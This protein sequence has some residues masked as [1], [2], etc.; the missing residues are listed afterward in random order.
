MI[1]IKFQKSFSNLFGF[2]CWPYFFLGGIIWLA[3]FIHASSFGIYEDDYILVLPAIGRTFS[4]LLSV[5][6]GYLFSWPQGR[7][8]FWILTDTWIWLGYKLGG[9]SGL[10]FGAFI[11][12]WICSFF[13]LKFLLRLL[14]FVPAF[15]GAIFFVLFPPDA[16]EQIIMHQAV[17]PL[18]TLCVI[19]FFSL[20]QKRKYFFASL[21]LIAI[22]LNYE[23]YLLASLGC[24]FLLLAQTPNKNFCKALLAPFLMTI[25]ALMA[26]LVLRQGIGESRA[27]EVLGEPMGPVLRGLSALLIGPFHLLVI[28][29]GRSTQALLYASWEERMAWAVTAGLVIFFLRSL[30]PGD[31]DKSPNTEITNHRWLLAAGVVMMVAPYFYRFHADYYPPTLNIGRLSSLHQVSALGASLLLASLIDFSLKSAQRN[32]TWILAGWAIWIT[33]FVP[34]GLRI[35][36]SQYVKSATLQKQFWLDLVSQIGDWR[37]GDPIMVDLNSFETNQRDWRPGTDGFTANWIT[38]YPNRCMSQLFVLP[39]TWAQKWP[40]SPEVFAYYRGCQVWI[41]KD[42]LALMTSYIHSRENPLV[43]RSG[44]FL[45]FRWEKGRLVRSSQPIQALDREF[46]PRKAEGGQ[47]WLEPVYTRLGA[48]LF[49]RPR[50]MWR[51]FPKAKHYP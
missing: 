19:G 40:A 26:V 15:L 11:L 12:Q 8:I 14:P 13:V 25:G 20:F 41:E 7:P 29:L 9:I 22:G 42:G 21:A 49:E 43:L 37:P 45:Y 38:N 27:V 30:V 1:D 46:V 16:G 31:K 47:H 18:T 32:Q 2:R 4:D 51:G 17:F 50:G 6:W 39:K 10:Y 35:Q 24:G 48:D 36:T 34:L 28:T 23:P 33:A 44:H 3:S 5:N